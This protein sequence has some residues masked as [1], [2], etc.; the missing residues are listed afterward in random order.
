MKVYNRKDLR[1]A[2]K[3]S[4]DAD[5]VGPNKVAQIS[6]KYQVGEFNDTVDGVAANVS[7]IV[8]TSDGTDRMEAGSKHMG[9]EQYIYLNVHLFVLYEKTAED[10]TVEWTESQSEDQI[11]DMEAA[12]MIWCDANID[13]RDESVIP[14]WMEMEVLTRSKITSAFIE[15]IEYRHEEFALQFTVAN[16]E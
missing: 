6:Y 15:G 14:P 13:R 4:I 2:L 1:T 8:I 5:L 7:V 9:P 16:P 12:F 11:D 3:A 10:G